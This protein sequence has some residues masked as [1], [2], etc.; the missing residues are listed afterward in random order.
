MEDLIGGSFTISN[1]GIWGSLFGTPIINMPQTAVL[2]VY[3]IQD[4]PVAVNGEVQIRPVS[5]RS[6]LF[7]GHTWNPEVWVSAREKANPIFDK[8]MYIALTYDH[9]IIDGREAVKFLNLV[10]GYLE[11]PSTM[12]L[13]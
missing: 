3:G 7:Q 9:R 5:P 8:I 13:H 12:L 10:K 11:E 2:G 4:R 6:H 1:S